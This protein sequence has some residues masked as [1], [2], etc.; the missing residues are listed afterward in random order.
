MRLVGLEAAAQWLE[1]GKSDLAAAKEVGTSE[2]F[3]LACYLSQQAAEKAL[4]AIYVAHEVKFPLTHSIG[5]LLRGLV[6]SYPEL[7]E[8]KDSATLLTLYE[9]T[10]RY[11]NVDTG[12]NPLTEFTR[13]NA[14]DAEQ[15]AGAI[16]AS[17]ENIYGQLTAKA[18]APEN[19]EETPPV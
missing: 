14:A 16:V 3:H 19:Q 13:K 2:R 6:G 1:L 11:I 15:A 12:F 5:E 4:K 9:A 10:T 7:D 17:C 18:P 8:F